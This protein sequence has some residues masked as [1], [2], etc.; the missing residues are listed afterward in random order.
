[1]TE[2]RN[3]RGQWST[4]VEN[5]DNEQLKTT[6]IEDRENNSNNKTQH[7]TA[8]ENDHDKQSAKT[9]L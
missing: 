7:S 6:L 1:M 5:N 9:E 8:G 2:T 3:N 4:E